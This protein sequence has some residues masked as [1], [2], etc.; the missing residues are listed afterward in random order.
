VDTELVDPVVLRRVWSERNVDAR[1][2][3]LLQSAWLA[4]ST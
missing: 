2:Y 3:L 1:S 4:A